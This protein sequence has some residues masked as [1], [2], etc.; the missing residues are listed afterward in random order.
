MANSLLDFVMSL[1]RDPDAAARYAENPDQAIF[2]ANLTNV[3]TADVS[4]LIPVVT[5]SLGAALPD[6]ADNVWASGAATA[7]FDAFDDQVPVQAVDDVHT[8]ITDYVDSSDD[9]LDSG[10]DALHDSN[11]PGVVGADDGSLQFDQPIID[12][13]PVFDLPADGNLSDTVIEVAD[14]DSDPSG[15]DIF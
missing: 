14:M 11:I 8:T 5:E 12:D 7:A 10:L 13:L 15:Y 3:T 2:D 9:V 4:N 1:V 6:L